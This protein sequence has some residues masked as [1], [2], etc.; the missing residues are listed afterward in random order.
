MLFYDEDMLDPVEESAGP[1]LAEGEHAVLMA[2]PERYRKVNPRTGRMKKFRRQRWMK[3]KVAPA[4]R[5]FRNLPRYAD[6]RPKVRFQ[7][8]LEIETRTEGGA[9]FGRAAD[10]KWYGW[11]HRAVYGFGVGT[12]IPEDCC[13]KKRGRKA[14]YKIETEEE[15]KEHAMGFSRAVS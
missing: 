2:R 15:A 14:P 4:D 10:G 3:T 1:E 7:D 12:E 8:W 11:S 6:G 5:T 13:Y 9:T